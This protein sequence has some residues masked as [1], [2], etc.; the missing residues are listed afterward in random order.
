M[1]IKIQ[2]KNIAMENPE[3][4]ECVVAL[5]ENASIQDLIDSIGWGTAD[6][7]EYYPLSGVFSWNSSYVPYLFV[8]GKVEYDVL[9]ES[10]HI[11]DFIYTHNISDNT[12]K[13]VV[14]YPW[15]GG[16]GFLELKEIW[17]HVW[18]CIEAIAVVC[19]I[20]GFSLKDLYNYLRTKFMDKGQPPHT[21]F[22]IVFSRKQWNAL[23]LAKLLD[24]DVDKAKDLLALCDYQYDRKQQQYMQS[25]HTEECK[26]KLTEVQVYD[27]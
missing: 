6:L 22:D 2:I 12:I 5:P 17:G 24:V 14:G 23:E 3:V 10:A 16:P 13:V 21:C 1:E 8:N 9:F 20:S 7:S 11:K 26:K 4:S 19:T 15:A 25:N 18:P 27:Y